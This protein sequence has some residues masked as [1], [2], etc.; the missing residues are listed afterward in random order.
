L[1]HFILEGHGA[2]EVDGV[3]YEWEAGDCV[4]LPIKSLGVEYQFFNLD[5]QNPARYLAATPNFFE[6][7][8]VDL[9]SSFEQLEDASD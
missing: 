3:R 6:V 4:A 1:V 2:V 5:A 8:G 7:L 9:G